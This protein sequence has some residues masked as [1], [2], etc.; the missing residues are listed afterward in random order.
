ME[1]LAEL[2]LIDTLPSLELVSFLSSFFHVSLLLLFPFYPTPYFI[3]H[4]SFK[5]PTFY[6]QVYTTGGDPDSV[7]GEFGRHPLYKMLGYFS[8]IGLLRLHSLLGDYYQAI[9]VSCNIFVYIHMLYICVYLFL[10]PS[11]HILYKYFMCVYLSTC[12]RLRV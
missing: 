6:L 2:A 3:L 12:K 1:H 11:P 10:S 8:L 5:P 4:S 7:A 9:K